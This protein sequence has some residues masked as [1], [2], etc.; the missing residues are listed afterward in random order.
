[1]GGSSNLLQGFVQSLSTTQLA[2]SQHMLTLARPKPGLCRLRPGAL[3]REAAYLWQEDAYCPQLLPPSK[4]DG[5]NR[6]HD[7]A[8][9]NQGI[10][11][12]NYEN[13]NRAETMT[14]VNTATT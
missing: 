11:I 1:M 12:S 2:F 6:A 3:N 7:R 9:H 4:K 5:M 10:P 8:G 14:S 13:F